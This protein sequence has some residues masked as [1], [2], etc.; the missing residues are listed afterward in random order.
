MV[1]LPTRDD[2]GRLPSA[3]SGR[4]IADYDTS[5]AGRGLASLG[6]Q[7][8]GAAD[9]VGRLSASASSGGIGGASQAERFE[10][11]RRFLEFTSSQ[12]QAYEDSKNTVDPGAFG[13]REQAQ[14][15][16]MDAAKA[17]FSTVPKALQPEYDAKL[18]AEEDDFLNKSRAFETTERTRYYGDE[19]NKGLT[20][21]ESG[22]FS[23]PGN[24]DKSFNQGVEYINSIPDESLSRIQKADLV[25]QWRSKAQLASLNGVTPQERIRLLGGTSP[26]ADQPTAARGQAVTR[27]M[28]GNVRQVISD[29]AARYGV[30]PNA[31]LVI[32]S[33]ESGGNP[34]AKNPKSSAGGLFQFI[35][36]TA[37]AYGLQNKFDAAQSAEAAARLARDNSDALERVLGRKPTTGELYLAH[38]QGSGGATKLLSNPN[39]RAVDVVGADAVRLNGGNADMTAGEFASLWMKK[40]GDTHVPDGGIMNAQFDVSR[41]DPRFADMNYQDAQKIIGGAQVEI[42]KQ[43]DEQAADARA[44]IEVASANAPVAILNT[45]NYDGDLPTAEQFIQAYG[46]DGADRYNKFKAEVDTSQQAYNMQTMPES[47]ISQLLSNAK[48]S[49]SGDTA[50]LDTVKYDTLT[51]AAQ[52]IIKAREADPASYVQQAFPNVAQAWEQAESSGDYRTALTATATAQ[53]MLGIRDMRL[54][55]KNVADQT[56]TQ[57]KDETATGQERIGAVTGMVFSTSD[58]AQRQAIFNQ[59]VDA[60]LPDATEGAFDAYARGD[61]GAGRRLMEAAIIDPSKLPGQAPFK[62]SEIDAEI[63]AKIMDEGQI[64]DIFYGLS[65][66]TVENQERAI[67]DSKLLTNAV[68]IRVRNGETL[69]AAIDGAAKDLYG[70][71]QAVTGDMDVNAQILIPKDA[72]PSAT[73]DGLA[74]LLPTVRSR[75]EGSMEIPADV[76]SKAGEKAVTEAV[77]TNYIDNVMAEGY[78]R[79]SGDGY[80]FIDP[81]VGA[82]VSGSD[83][84]PIIFSDEDV[85]AAPRPKPPEEDFNG[86]PQTQ[87]QS[88]KEIDRETYGQF[89]YMLKELEK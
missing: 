85:R 52:Q 17:F 7:I 64:G 15:Q 37:R 38:Q 2:L 86:L 65:D 1:Q 66:G 48:P 19:I 10:T 76:A 87:P 28:D 45:G 57:F 26:V 78:F 4:I 6:E 35:D 9:T 58:P 22:L 55:P 82:A 41:A 63:Q 40:A 33:I 30:D 84:Q 79:N 73:L 31:L 12:R 13:F 27:G 83:G 70:D 25:K 16:Y 74:G 49:A 72:D 77:R 53:Q 11:N 51:K 75:I 56:I 8:S 67:R 69:E 68:N 14:K 34:N 18:F 24:F 23:E 88:Q 62:S 5:A 80:V 71:V 61:E 46:E 54:L 21:I 42:R 43:Y 20:T 60:G 36:S 39:A 32:A 44:R 81:F 59:L 47:E 50:A 3:R 29:A 89:D